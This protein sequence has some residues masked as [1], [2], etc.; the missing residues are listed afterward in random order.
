MD[1]V[2]TSSVADTVLGTPSWV[3]SFPIDETAWGETL[4]QICAWIRY[5]A[6]RL[7]ENRHTYNAAKHGFGTTPSTASLHFFAEDTSALVLGHEGASIE[8]LTY[9]RTGPGER[10]WT[11]TT[12][13][14]DPQAL[15]T[16]TMVAIRLL[17]AA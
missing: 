8:A 3:A 15:W 9:E 12:R 16:E 10:V 13:F 11:L 17:N 4:D 1:N 2:L 14:Y 6:R 7:E 5:M